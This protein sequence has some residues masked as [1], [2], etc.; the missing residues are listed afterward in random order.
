M[1]NYNNRLEKE[2]TKKNEPLASVM[3]FLRPASYLFTFTLSLLSS[4]PEL[5]LR[6]GDPYSLD[7]TIGSL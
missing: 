7:L 5:T 4:I 2:K 1:K 6:K 3:N